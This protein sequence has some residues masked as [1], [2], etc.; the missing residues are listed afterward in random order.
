MKRHSTHATAYNFMQ[1]FLLPRE[2]DVHAL[3]CLTPYDVPKMSCDNACIYRHHILIYLLHWRLED[4][5]T[6][7]NTISELKT[8]VKIYTWNLIST[9]LSALYAIKSTLS[10]KPAETLALKVDHFVWLRKPRCPWGP[11]GQA[12]ARATWAENL[13]REPQKTLTRLCEIV[14]QSSVFFL[15]I[16]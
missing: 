8:Y 6:R 4:T 10:S 12:R 13:Y 3:A 11:R 2:F 5:I 16:L 14:W 1:T 9:S 7:F 15:P